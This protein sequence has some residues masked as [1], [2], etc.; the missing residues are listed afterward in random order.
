MQNMPCVLSR[1]KHTAS[2]C[3]M[4]SCPRYSVNLEGCTFYLLMYRKKIEVERTKAHFLVLL[5]LIS[6]SLSRY[7]MHRDRRVNLGTRNFY[8][9]VYS[10]DSEFKMNFSLFTCVVVSPPRNYVLFI[11]RALKSFTAK[12]CPVCSNFI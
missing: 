10:P 8:R 6:P 3:F 7:D 2:V 11:C 4:I 5:F 9:T 12:A 1:S